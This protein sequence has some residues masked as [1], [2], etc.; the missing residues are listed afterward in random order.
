MRMHLTGDANG[1]IGSPAADRPHHLFPG[2]CALPGGGL[3]ALYTAGNGFESADQLPYYAVSQDNGR[4]W[5]TGKPLF[6]TI[7]LPGGGVFSCCAKAALRPDGGLLALGYGFEREEPTLSLSDYAARHGRFPRCRNFVCTSPAGALAWSSPRFVEHGYSG[8]ETSG[9]PLADGQGNLLF[10]GPPFVLRQQSQRGLVFRSG[11]GGASWQEHGCY[12]THPDIAPWE[13]RGCR[14]PGGRLWLVFWAYDLRREKHLNNALVWSDDGG[15]SWSAPMDSGIHCQASCLLALP[16]YPGHM[17]LAGAVREGDQPGIRLYLLE[18]GS[19]RCLAE[20][21][22]LN[23]RH[24]ANAAGG[25]ETQF[26]SLRFG[27]PGLL[28]LD[29]GSLLLSYWS[30][31]DGRYACRWQS[32]RLNLLF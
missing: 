10:F 23:L 11:D 29:D 31:V 15:R 12:F 22:L 9:P 5:S 7:N 13:T 30:Q 20:Q 1:E 19:G 26:A 27:Q 17:L 3:L 14:M 8:I 21:T 4:Q 2:L 32:L 6:S 18:A 16:G 25:I 28:A 24:M